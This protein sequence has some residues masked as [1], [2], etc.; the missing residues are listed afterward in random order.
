MCRFH[1]GLP[2]N[3]SNNVW[4]VIGL[5]KEPWTED[6]QA[7]PLT[8]Q[9]YLYRCNNKATVYFGMVEDVV[10]GQRL[11]QRHCSGHSSVT[12]NNLGCI[13]GRS[14]RVCTYST[15]AV[16]LHLFH[17]MSEYSVTH[18]AEWEWAGEVMLMNANKQISHVFF[19]A[20]VKLFCEQITCSELL[21]VA[22]AQ[23]NSREREFIQADGVVTDLV[24]V[25]CVLSHPIGFH[26]HGV[27][28]CENKTTKEHHASADSHILS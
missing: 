11:V 7:V 21:L 1:K 10:L 13:S 23:I 4:S 20:T 16:Q 24:C 15:H 28:A 12:S 17:T 27:K 26:W 2:Q 14:I 22:R 18:W 19:W 6:V 9:N 5:S 3:H 25:R 8:Q